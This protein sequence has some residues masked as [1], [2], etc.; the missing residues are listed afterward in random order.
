[1]SA[2]DA[3]DETVEALAALFR[4]HPAWRAAARSIREGAESDVYFRHLPGRRWHLT[5]CAGAAELRPGPAGVPDFVF[6]FP[7]EAV[8]ALGRARGGVGDFAVRLFELVLDDDPER[9]VDLRI[10]APF[11]QL[12][13]NG[14]VGLLRRAGPRLAAF[15]ATRGVTNAAQVARLVRR[16]RGASPFEW[17]EAPRADHGRGPDGLETD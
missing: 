9:H 8:R 7:P 15:G 11:R 2:S 6:R 13:R 16:L 1:V 12:A 3:R 4:T 17:E 5:R 10:V 14:Y